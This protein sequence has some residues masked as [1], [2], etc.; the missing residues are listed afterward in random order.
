MLEDMVVALEHDD[1]LVADGIVTLLIVDILVY[2]NGHI[3]LVQG[4][5][6][7]MK[8]EVEII[9]LY[10]SKNKILIL[11]SEELKIYETISK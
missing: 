2:G 5:N 11:D 9:N 6:E 8:E 1:V 4:E 3:A 7:V 10:T